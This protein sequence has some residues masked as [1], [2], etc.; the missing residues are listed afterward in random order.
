[1]FERFLEKYLYYYYYTSYPIHIFLISLFLYFYFGVMSSIEIG[2]LESF[3]YLLKIFAFLVLFTYFVVFL[4]RIYSMNPKRSIISM[5]FVAII[6]L[7]LVDVST[8]NIIFSLLQ[9]LLVVIIVGSIFY[10]W[11]GVG[12]IQPDESFPTFKKWGK[13]FSPFKGKGVK[14]KK[15]KKG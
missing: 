3:F 14:L 6:C 11:I 4:F 5:V 9:D 7:W 1:M 10:V 12:L 13:E 2:F 8:E 15:K